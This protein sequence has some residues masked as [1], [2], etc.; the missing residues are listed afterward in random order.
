VWY[1]NYTVGIEQ[2]FFNTTVIDPRV[3]G[4]TRNINLDAPMYLV[5]ANNSFRF[6]HSWL[7]ELN[8]QYTSPF[9]ELI[10]EIEKPMHGLSAAVGKSFLKNDA[11]SFR[12]S[13]E[14]IL[15]RQILYIRTDYGNCFIRQNNDRYA[16][17]VQ[18][19]ISYRFNSANSKYKGT[20]AGQSAKNRM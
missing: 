19:R 2:Q 3:E 7:L 10:A 20:G 15:N 1:P 8:Y 18:L 16:P 6:K 12:L 9:N 4:G 5:Q 14:D 11:L 17:C 13:W